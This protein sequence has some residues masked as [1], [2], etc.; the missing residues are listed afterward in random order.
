[1]VVENYYLTQRDW[2]HTTHFVVSLITC[3]DLANAPEW[4]TDGDYVQ[5][6]DDLVQF[7]VRYAAEYTIFLMSI[8]KSESI[9]DTEFSA[10]IVLSFC[11]LDA[12]QDVPE[13]LLREAEALRAKVFNELSRYYRDKLK[14]A[15][16]SSNLGKLMT[17]FH[18]MSE[19]S[20][21]L[22]EELRMYSYLFGVYSTDVLV[23]DVFIQ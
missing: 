15:E 19:A 10:L 11:E 6:K 17:M 14:H 4:V 1:S 23:R 18:T 9:T 2:R 7:L 12:S 13:S 20:T 3:F 8:R 21:M 5:R 22:A 16:Y